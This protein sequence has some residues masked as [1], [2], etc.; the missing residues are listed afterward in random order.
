MRVYRPESTAEAHVMSAAKT[1]A[2]C[3]A[4]LNEREALKER[5]RLLSSRLTTLLPVCTPV[6]KLMVQDTLNKHGFDANRGS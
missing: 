6:M 2:E 3:Q 1:C 5:V 4:L